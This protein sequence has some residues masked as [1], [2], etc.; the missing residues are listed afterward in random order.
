[1]AFSCDEQ[2]CVCAIVKAFWS[3]D[4]LRDRYNLREALESQSA[5]LFAEVSTARERAE[6]MRMAQK[7]DGYYADSIGRES[8]R[9]YRLSVRQYHVRFHLRIAEIGGSPLL[10][11]AIERAVSMLDAVAEAGLGDVVVVLGEE[12][13]SIR[14]AVT[15]RTERLEPTMR[16]KS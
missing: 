16:S 14:G 11:Q 9:E 10:R 1:M 13:A 12:A 2:S 6:L 5:R 15:W 3:G 4:E 8:D 7:L